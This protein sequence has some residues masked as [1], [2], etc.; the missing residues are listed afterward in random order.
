MNRKTTCSYCAGITFDD[1][2][3]NC[4]ACGGPR[5]SSRIEY[6]RSSA[7]GT[8]VE[9]KAQHFRV[10]EALDELNQKFIEGEIDLNN[11]RA[12]MSRIPTE[13]KCSFR[14]HEG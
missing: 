14:A 11:F 12:A 4:A 8:A 13:I 7:R 6:S 9:N 3:G 2:R 5:S 10:A 1:A